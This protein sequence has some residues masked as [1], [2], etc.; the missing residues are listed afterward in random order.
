MVSGSIM[1]G[2]VIFLVLFIEDI[3]LVL[4]WLIKVFCIK[5]MKGLFDMLFLN[6]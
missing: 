3:V 6:I 1:W 2:G 5:L 4:R